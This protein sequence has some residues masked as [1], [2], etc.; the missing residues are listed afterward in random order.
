MRKRLSLLLICALLVLAMDATRA[1]QEV[2]EYGP[3]KGT[4]VIVGGGATEG[5]GIIERFI[6]IAGGSE[7][8]FIVVPTAGGNKND[9]GSVR[10][11]DEATIVAPWVKRGIKNVK[12]LHTHD[13]KVADTEAFVKDLKEADAVWFNGGSQWNIVD[14]YMNT[15]TLKEFTNVLARGGVIG[16]SSAGASIQGEYL[17]RGDT[18]GPNVMMTQEPNHQEAFK[19]LRRSAIDQHINTRNRWDDLI[20]VIQKHPNLLGIGLSEGTAIIVTGDTFEVIGKWKVAVHDNTRLYQP[21]EKPYYVL[22]AGD[23][24]NMKTRKL[25]RLGTGGTMRREGT[26]GDVEAPAQTWQPP[27]DAQRCPSKWGAGDER[28]SGNHMKP[29]SVLRAVRLMKTGEVFE[30]GR[31]LS[32]T[33]PFFGT[34]RFEVNLKRTVMNPQPNRRGSN[35]EIVYSEIGQV[36]TQFDGFSHQTIGPT[37]YNCFQL[38]AIAT[39]TGFT[40]LGIEHAGTLMTRGVLIDVAALKGV[41]MLGETYE[42]T[43]QDLQNAL[44]RQKLTLQPGD[45][46][47]IHTG[48]GQLWGQDNAR[49]V[50]SAPG[51]GV[52][53]AEWL[54]KQ[55]PMLVGSDNWGVEVVPNPDPQ[56]NQPVHQIML[57]VNGIHLLENL[58]LDDLAARQVHEFGFIVQPL[59][60]Q[61]GTG[62]TVVPVAIR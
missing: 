25:E 11:Y 51:I 18:S 8:K 31:V 29:E 13:P 58:K 21:W 47:L 57:V 35:E 59:K 2:P 4:L 24:F 28:G 15:R 48:W 44:A 61:G 23:V 9:D 14:S 7:K 55:D 3:A 49:Y 5:T 46:V 32:G 43:A 1:Y 54:A 52:G 26:E 40:K 10:V 45:A 50:K 30:L 53:A 20:P 19:F 12:M 33:M 17:V 41:S 22:S 62:S 56:L 60:I 39:R 36:G 42:I 37:L 34:R 38:D 6:Q 27:S 16:G